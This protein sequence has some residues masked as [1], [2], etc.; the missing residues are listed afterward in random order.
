MGVVLIFLIGNALM[1]CE[2]SNFLDSLRSSVFFVPP[3]AAL[4][5]DFSALLRTP[6]GV[7]QDQ[8]CY[9]VKKLARLQSRHDG[10]SRGHM[11]WGGTFFAFFGA[12]LFR[13]RY[14]WNLKSSENGLW[15]IKL[16]KFSQLASL[17]VFSVFN[18]ISDKISANLP[19]MSLDFLSF[20]TWREIWWDFWSHWQMSDR[21]VCVG[22]GEFGNEDQSKK[23][24]YIQRGRGRQNSSRRLWS[25]RRK[26]SQPRSGNVPPWIFWRHPWKNPCYH[27]YSMDQHA[28]SAMSFQSNNIS[29]GK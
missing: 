20:S 18:F 13:N 17:A 5:Y 1:W 16:Q 28:G 15:V 11:P 25:I 14:C 23:I 27:A 8:N 2:N 21:C 22:G 26:F 6:N 29:W 4:S 12:T 9:P 24:L 7:S 19:L 10:G 3:S